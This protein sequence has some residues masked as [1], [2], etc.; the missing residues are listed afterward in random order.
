MHWL[1]MNNI[2][3]IYN[4]M[5]TYNCRSPIDGNRVHA[6]DLKFDA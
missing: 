2:L 6:N 1:G 3:L 4:P 5:V